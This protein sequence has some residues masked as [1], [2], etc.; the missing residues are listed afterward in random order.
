L[1]GGIPLNTNIRIAGDE[2]FP[3][4][5]KNPASEEAKELVKTAQKLANITKNFKGKAPEIEISLE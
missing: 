1:L 4:V 3:I 5:L 2:G